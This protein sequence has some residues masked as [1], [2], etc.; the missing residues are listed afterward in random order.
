MPLSQLLYILPGLLRHSRGM[1]F[2]RSM[3]QQSTPSGRLS[4]VSALLLTLHPPLPSR[5]KKVFQPPRLYAHLGYYLSSA[6]SHFWGIPF[7]PVIQISFMLIAFSSAPQAFPLS[8]QGCLQSLQ[9]VC[10]LYHLGHRLL[11]AH[12]CLL[13]RQLWHAGSILSRLFAPGMLHS[14]SCLKRVERRTEHLAPQ[15]EARC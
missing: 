10:S 6:S 3:G 7:F 13:Q 11:P 1:G 9:Q 8:C 14:Y 15:Q 4:Q 5:R 2:L 12:S